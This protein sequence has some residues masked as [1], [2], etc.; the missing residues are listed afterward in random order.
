MRTESKQDF[1]SQ[2]LGHLQ[3]VCSPAEYAN[4]IQPISLKSYDSAS[5]VLSVP[6]VFVQEYLLA[7]YK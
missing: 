7:N 4:W 5:A 3:T 1:W 2:F 6:N